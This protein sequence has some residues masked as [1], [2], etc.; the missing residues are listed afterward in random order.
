MSFGTIITLLTL[1]ECL[2]CEIWSGDGRQWPIIFFARD[3]G[4]DYCP[5][6]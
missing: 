5:S 3:R 2:K 6:D 4:Y 1:L